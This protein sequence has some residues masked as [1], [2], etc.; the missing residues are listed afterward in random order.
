[1]S[2]RLSRRGRWLV[3]APQYNA[4]HK[5]Q[6]LERRP[7][8]NRA[9]VIGLW[10]MVLVIQLG[11]MAFQLPLQYK[12]RRNAVTLLQ[13]L[14]VGGQGR[15]SPL[16][17]LFLVTEVNKDGFGRAL[18]QLGFSLLTACR[19]SEASERSNNE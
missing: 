5:Y 7:A 9:P 11:T 2:G 19:V 12:S 17:A 14:Q 18:E 15:I 3:V 6:P 10:K 13:S 8:C 4:K 16:R 1:M